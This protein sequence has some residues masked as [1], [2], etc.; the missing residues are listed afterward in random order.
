MDKSH[1]RKKLNALG[2][3]VFEWML[4]IDFDTVEFRRSRK[5]VFETY[6][7]VLDKSDF[8]IKRGD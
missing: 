8:S 7:Q 5:N 6:I 3:D 1:A 4:A 2:T